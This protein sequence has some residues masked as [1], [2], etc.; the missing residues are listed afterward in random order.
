MVP[1]SCYAL[2]GAVFTLATVSALG[3]LLFQAVSILRKRVISLKSLEERLLMV[4]CGTACL[5]VLVFALCAVNLARKSTYV[6]LGFIAIAAAS[7]SAVYRTFAASLA[8]AWAAR[9]FR[10]RIAALAVVAVVLAWLPFADLPASGSSQRLSALDRAHGFG[11]SGDALANWPAIV[12]MTPLYSFAFGR[13]LAVTLVNCS[14]LILFAVLLAVCGQRLVTRLL[15]DRTL[16]HWSVRLGAAAFILAYFLYF[17]AYAL[18]G[19]FAIDDPINLMY[20]WQQGTWALIRAQLEFFSTYYRPMGGVFYLSMF[21]LAGLDPLPYRM[22]A[23]SILVLNLAVFYRCARLISGSARIGWLAALLAA[24][25]TRLLHLYYSNAVIYDVLCFLFYFA[26]LGWYV[27]VRARGAFCNWRQT[28]ILMVLYICALNAKEMAVTLPIT[29]LLFELLFHPPLQ[30]NPK[31]LREWLARE[32][33]VVCILGLITAVYVAGKLTG[34]DSL[35]QN[36][37]YQPDL[38]VAKFLGTVT[39]NVRR[40]F[41]LRAGLAPAAVAGAWA[42]LLLFAWVTKSR[43]G[44]FCLLFAATSKLPTAFIGR[45]EYNLYIPLG[46]WAMLVA[47]AVW[48]AAEFVAETHG[49]GGR[50]TAIAGAVVAAFVLLNA[51]LLWSEKQMIGRGG[52]S[53]QDERWSILQQ[54][55]QLRISP[56]HGNS[57]VFLNDPFGNS[58]MASL[59]KLWFRDLSLSVYLMRQAALPEGTIATMDYVI[60]YRDG[61]FTLVKPRSSPEREHR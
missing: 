39:E 51:C 20:Y 55:G 16:P 10:G 57:I 9:S 2:F 23:L 6:G 35:I 37:S 21:H 4:V 24:Y 25:H 18:Q 61:N 22:V 44:A 33:R 12:D 40:L 38:T 49:R 26:A 29:L 36:T 30:F 19:R 60:D 46:A 15:P 28:G 8:T 53:E 13:E 17:A 58:E 11:Q 59:T 3:A 43:Y 7:R 14:L 41:Y 50:R 47:A 5:S 56:E 31:T 34:P 32:G 45:S 52:I 42:A 27:G 48:Q 54:F 1:S